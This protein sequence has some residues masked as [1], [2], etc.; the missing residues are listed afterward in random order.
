MSIAQK[1][2]MSLRQNNCNTVK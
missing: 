2:M 1:T